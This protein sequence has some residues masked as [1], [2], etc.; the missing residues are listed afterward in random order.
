MRGESRKLEYAMPLPP[1]PR[2]L[3]VLLPGRALGAQIPGIDKVFL[4]GIDLVL[5][6]DVLDA[7]FNAVLGKYDMFLAHALRDGAL[8]LVDAKI[9]LVANPCESGEDCEEDDEGEELATYSGAS[10]SILGHL[11]V[12]TARAKEGTYLRTEG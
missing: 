1:E 6:L 10:V 12:A 3:L 11:Q 2:I 9:Y 4:R 5:M 7:D 8:H